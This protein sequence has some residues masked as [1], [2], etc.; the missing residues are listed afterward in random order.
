V[1]GP[2]LRGAL[3]RAQGFRA[4]ARAFSKPRDLGLL[5]TDLAALRRWAR[6]PLAAPVAQA[7]DALAAGP[8]ALAQAHERL[9]GASGSVP[10]RESAY[11]DPRRV[12]PTELADLRGFLLAFGLEE[13]GELADHVASECELASLLALK[14]ALALADG[15]RERAEV[16]GGAY[17]ALLADHLAGF[18][19]RFAARV[20]EAG[21]PAFYRAAA[22]ALET[23]VRGEVGT[24]CGPPPPPPAGCGQPDPDACSELG[25]GGCGGA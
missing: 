11:A 7:C 13:R 14:Q 20:R 25:C 12:A 5:R 18:V 24:A 3:E 23:L 22:D 17:R 19:P 6:G 15:E 10:A 9:F 4:L 1:T 8:D 21:A 2:A 16:A